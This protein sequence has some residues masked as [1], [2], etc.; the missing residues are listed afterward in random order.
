MNSCDKGKRGER[1]FAAFLRAHGFDAR[2]GQQF[3][4]G[5]NSPDVVSEVLWWL[6]VEVKRV[7]HLNL[8][9]ACAQAAQDGGGKPWIVA[10]RRNRG[11][12]FITMDSESLH[13]LLRGLFPAFELRRFTERRP[14]TLDAE[15]FLLL[16][17]G[18]GAR[19]FTT[20][21]AES[22]EEGTEERILA[23]GVVPPDINKNNQQERDREEYDPTV[24]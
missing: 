14:I 18:E 5:A 9:E 24:R 1:E 19:R 6:H 22:T 12:W 2:R 3:S 15:L 4:G 7:E 21:N 10:H 11:L 8:A 20:E 23:G 17:R 16:L 13:C